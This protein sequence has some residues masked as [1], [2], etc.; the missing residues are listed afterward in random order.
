M[1]KGTWN[2]RIVVEMAFSLLTVVCKAK[3][4]YHRLEADIEARLAYSAA[5]F[6]I[7]LNKVLL[8]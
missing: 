8:K 4:I 7:I 5:M 2:D 1:Q 6:N 3:K